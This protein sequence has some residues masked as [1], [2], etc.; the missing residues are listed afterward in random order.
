[1]NLQPNAWEVHGLSNRAVVFST[2]TD[3]IVL[4]PEGGGDRVRVLLERRLNGRGYRNVFD[5]PRSVDIEEVMVDV[6]SSFRRCVHW[7]L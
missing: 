4:D 7:F 6:P 2:T 1:M 3:R 5:E